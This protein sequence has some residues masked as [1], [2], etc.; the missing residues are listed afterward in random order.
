MISHNRRQPNSGQT[1]ITF[2]G[3]TRVSYDIGD[4]VVV[5]GVWKMARS[6]FCDLM[7]LVGLPCQP[8][9]E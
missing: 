2:E 7:A 5:N 3:T 4:A 9:S 1:P 6:T 8:E